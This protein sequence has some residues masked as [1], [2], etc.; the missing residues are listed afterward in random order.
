[1]STFTH[2]HVTCLACR[3]PFE[4]D[5]IKSMHITR[6][7]AV[8]LDI[9]EGR[10]QR[11]ACPR[12]GHLHDVVN[13]TIY[14]DFD[15][16][17]YIAV[18]PALPADWR[19]ARALHERIFDESFTFGPPVAE[20]L[21]LGMRRRLVFGFDALREKVRLWDADLDD[22]VVEWLKGVHQREL[23]LSPIDELWRL[24]T[25][26]PGGH[27]M[28]ARVTPPPIVGPEEELIQRSQL[29]GHHTVTRADYERG[30]RDVA[31]ANQDFPWLADDWCVDLFATAPRPMTQA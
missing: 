7:P 28:F 13:R 20:E 26:L 19:E 3:A 11:F 12:C 15:H 24:S 21:G 6:L 9:V 16:Q 29:L 1:L 31:R 5:L 4:I 14:T 18:E 2:H 30:L 27:L 10:S 23:G 25:V 8:R 22:R 17:Q